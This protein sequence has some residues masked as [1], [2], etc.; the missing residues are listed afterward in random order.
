MKI[1]Y[2]EQIELTPADRSV[3]T[4][5]RRKK[6]FFLLG[7]Y[8][9]L[10]AIVVVVIYLSGWVGTGYIAEE[11]MERQRRGSAILAVI[12]FIIL[13]VFFVVYYFKTVLPYTRDLKKGLKTVSWFYPTAYKTPY[14]D[15]FFLK[16]GSAKKPMLPITREMFYAVKPGVLACILFAPVS[17]FVLSLDIDGLQI[18]Y[19]ESNT[20]LEL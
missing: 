16:T 20:D 19:N 15:S 5:M 12:S 18:I 8:I 14:F 2:R 1:I 6:T 4:A 17:R 9:A 3:L 7:A 11:K 10:I 13:T